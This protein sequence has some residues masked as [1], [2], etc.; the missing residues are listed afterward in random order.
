[1]NSDFGSRD[2]ETAD[3][4][5][6]ATEEPTSQ[7]FLSESIEQFEYQKLET[8]LV[9]EDDVALNEALSLRLRQTGLQVVSAFDGVT[10][11]Q[12]AVE[13]EPELVVLDLCLPGMDGGKFLHFLRN[14]PGGLTADVVAITGSDD[15]RLEERVLGGGGRALL[16]KPLSP[17]ELVGEVMAALEGR[18]R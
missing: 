11:L 9:V 14:S 17:R 5:L 8:V 7:G 2:F 12:H 4:A 1:M 16:R 15:R 18:D 6:T 10:A 3:P 13:L